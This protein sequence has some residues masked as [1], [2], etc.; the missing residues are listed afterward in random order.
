MAECEICFKWFQ[1][2]AKRSL[3]AFSEMVASGLAK[4]AQPQLNNNETRQDLP[5]ARFQFAV[6]VKK[7]Q[8]LTAVSYRA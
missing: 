4:T 7:G 6:L 3:T 1:K 5:L 2:Y 8:E